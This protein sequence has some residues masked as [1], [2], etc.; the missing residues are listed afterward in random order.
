VPLPANPKRYQKHNR[1]FFD[2]EKQKPERKQIA[3]REQQKPKK[4]IAEKS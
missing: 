3:V 2:L 1:I 4:K